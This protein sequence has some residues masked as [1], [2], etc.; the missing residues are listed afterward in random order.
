M[1]GSLLGFGQGQG[2]YPGKF[3]S[4]LSW[5]REG[6][7]LSPSQDLMSSGQGENFCFESRVGQGQ[8]CVE[9]K[10]THSSRV[11][12]VTSSHKQKPT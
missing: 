4:G 12:E 10:K 11:Q 5:V 9:L 8:A 2:K 3:W 6:Q 7:W 1:F